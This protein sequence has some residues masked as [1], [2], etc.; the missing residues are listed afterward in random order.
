MNKSKK[1]KKNVVNEK[2]EMRNEKREKRKE[3]RVMN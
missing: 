3:D 1:F 2:W